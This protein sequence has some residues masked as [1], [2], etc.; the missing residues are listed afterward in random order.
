LPHVLA[1]RPIWP[2]TARP[3]HPSPTLA[4]RWACPVGATACPRVPLCSPCHVGPACH[5]LHSRVVA[6]GRVRPVSSSPISSPKPRNVPAVPTSAR[7]VATIASR[8]ITP[9]RSSPPPA[10]LIPPHSPVNSSPLRPS[11]LVEVHRGASP[12]AQLST[13]GTTYVVAGALAALGAPP[14][15][16]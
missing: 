1:F 8:G 13:L 11:C 4:A 14:P 2:A 3:S 15:F 9:L 6:Y 10:H 16:R 12:S 7:I 5:A